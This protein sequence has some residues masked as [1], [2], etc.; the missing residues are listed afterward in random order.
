MHLRT[1]NA[2][3]V[4]FIEHCPNNVRHAKIAGL[5]ERVKGQK[6]ATEKGGGGPDTRERVGERRSNLCA[7][8]GVF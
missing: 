4:H 2:K 1:N 6:R 8:S 7:S 5:R 3:F